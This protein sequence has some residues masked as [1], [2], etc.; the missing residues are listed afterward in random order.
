[1][2][3]FLPFSVSRETPPLSKVKTLLRTNS[4]K[5]DRIS[6]RRFSLSTFIP[7][8]PFFSFF[9]KGKRFVVIDSSSCL[10]FLYLSFFLL[11]RVEKKNNNNKKQ[12]DGNTHLGPSKSIIAPA[13]YQVT[14]LGEISCTSTIHVK[15][16]VLPFFTYTSSGP[17]IFACTS[18]VSNAMMKKIKG[19]N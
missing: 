17:V 7:P 1:M 15:L 11:N 6:G 5:T 4:D 13:W 12:K 9:S 3:P 16:I 18:G 8:P 14:L 10:S 2:V 19:F